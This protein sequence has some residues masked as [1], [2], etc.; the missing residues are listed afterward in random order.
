MEKF[1]RIVVFLLIIL[2]NLQFASALELDTADSAAEV[3]AEAITE[4]AAEE[5]AEEIVD[6]EIVIQDS[7]EPEAETPEVSPQEDLSDEVLSDETADTA[8]EI[9]DG[10][11]DEENKEDEENEENN[12]ETEAELGPSESPEPIADTYSAPVP[13]AAMALQ[14]VNGLDVASLSF[15][16]GSISVGIIAATRD[17]W[18]VSQEPTV[19]ALGV[20]PQGTF[21]WT[22]SAPTAA[23]VNGETGAVTPLKVGSTTITV[24]Y[25]YGGKSLSAKYKLTLTNDTLPDKVAISPPLSTALRLGD[26][27]NLTCGA[28]LGGLRADALFTWSS[29]NEKVA[30]VTKTDDTKAVV[31]PIGQGS[32]VIT[33]KSHNG[34]TD[35]IKVTVTNQYLPAAIA[36][37]PSGTV[38]LDL[39][40]EAAF[41]VS[42]QPSTAK[43]AITATYPKNAAADVYLVSETENSAQYRVVPK[44]TGQIKITF[45]AAGLGKSASVTFKIYDSKLPDSVKLASGGVEFANNAIIG[46]YSMLEPVSLTAIPLRMDGGEAK[47]DLK[48]TASGA[49]VSNGVVTANKAGTATVTVRTHNGKTAKARIVFFDPRRATGIELD[50]DPTFRMPL[51]SAL[52]V[53]AEVYPYSA[54]AFTTVEWSSSNK[55]IV[56]FDAKTG[57]HVNLIIKKKGTVTITAKSKETGVKKSF[58]LTIYEDK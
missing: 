53:S 49:T 46:T 26:T 45:K 5:N 55:S 21:A 29:S 6:E 10:V 56:D 16:N 7:Q 44:K 15:A 4:E 9:I 14:L 12:E 41:T 23:S 35:K 57:R 3:I 28:F 24:T 37:S 32:A 43:G 19:A 34:K 2:M 52:D 39:W 31:T 54:V 11:T 47:S 1:R 18:L 27:L 48:W 13:V 17:P 36:V 42:L 20:S 40:A 58:K 8:G 50:I 22:S 25:K 30:T 51:G 33:V 38:Q